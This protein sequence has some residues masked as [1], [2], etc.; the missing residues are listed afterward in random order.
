M[1]LFRISTSEY[2]NDLSGTGAKL[3]GGR[4]NKKG[5]ALLYCSQNISLSV[6]EILVHFDGLAVPDKLKLIELELPE[7]YIVDYSLSKFKKLNDKKD[8]E[9]QFKSEGQKWILSEKSLALRVPSII[10]P[11]EYNILIN[12]S[13]PS[14]RFLKK[15]KI[16]KLDLDDRLFKS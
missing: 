13:H 14:F 2:I 6:L 7:K 5:T 4:W 10:I 1:K 15:K 8:A 16:R 3:Y 11:L 12:P 9:L